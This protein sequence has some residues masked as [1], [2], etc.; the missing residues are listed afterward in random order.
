VKATLERIIKNPRSGY[1]FLFKDV[2]A[3]TTSGNTVQII[4][5]QP[6]G[7]FLYNMTTVFITP[8]ESGGV[9]AKLYEGKVG[10]GPFTLLE[11]VKGQRL[12]LV[13]NP[14]YWRQG[15]PKL[16]RLVIRPIP[17]EPT[18]VAALRAGEV[19]IANALSLESY[20]SLEKDPNFQV[21]KH[22]LWQVTYLS[23]N[24]TQKPLDDPRVRQ[25]ISM[26]ST[27]RRLSSSSYRRVCWGAVDSAGAV[28]VG[29]LRACDSGEL[30]GDSRA[31][32]GGGGSSARRVTLPHRREPHPPQHLDPSPRHR[33]PARGFDDHAG[34]VAVFLRNRSPAVDSHVGLDGA[35]RSR[36]PGDCV[37]GSA[38]AGEH[39]GSCCFGH[40]LS[41]RWT[42]RLA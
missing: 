35:R 18:K 40:Q 22:P 26:A 3:I 24:V 25:A 15:F 8:P 33:Y 23:V 1:N 42:A 10:T 7:A 39:A 41:W 37:V 17:E 2:E 30:L 32:M 16:D 14:N 28:G 34:V 36:V 9:I 29:G 4:T 27:A 11:W 20:R 5:R 6:D 31:A 38:L 19:D 21:M 12:V 13:K